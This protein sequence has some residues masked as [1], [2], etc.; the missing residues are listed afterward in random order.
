MGRSNYMKVSLLFYGASK[1]AF[2]WPQLN[3]FE[4]PDSSLSINILLQP[5]HYL[6]PGF[7]EANQSTAVEFQARGLVIRRDLV[8]ESAA[9]LKDTGIKLVLEVFEMRRADLKALGEGIGLVGN[10]NEPLIFAR[11][12]RG[13]HVV[14]EPG[15]GK[16]VG[17]DR[18]NTR[19][20]SR[21]HD[22]EVQTTWILFFIPYVNSARRCHQSTMSTML[23]GNSMQPARSL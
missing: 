19:D 12:G 18:T 10:D 23:E 6:L 1:G 17:L 2:E 15:D 13:C 8:Q 11:C 22:D 20:E 14:L 5:T 9:H 7:C 16:E 21:S 3:L 4:I